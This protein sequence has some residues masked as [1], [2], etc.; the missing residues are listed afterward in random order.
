MNLYDYKTG[1][2]IRSL[3]VSEAAEYERLI[4]DDSTHTGAVD[5]GFAG[6]P[7]VTVYAI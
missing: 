4:A 1:D 5:G 7:G 2:F 6:L 3:D